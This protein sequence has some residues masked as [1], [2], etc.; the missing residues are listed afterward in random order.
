MK[1]MTLK[2]ISAGIAAMLLCRRQYSQLTGKTTWFITKTILT[3]KRKWIMYSAVKA[4]RFPLIT[5]GKNCHHKPNGTAR[6]VLCNLDKNK[7]LHKVQEGEVNT[8]EVKVKFE[9]GTIK[10]LRYKR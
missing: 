7:P 4:A 1:T 10:Y 5:N 3:A 8:L 6:Q 9:E 2:K